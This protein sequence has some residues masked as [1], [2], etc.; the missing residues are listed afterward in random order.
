MAASFSD[1]AMHEP[2]P[3]VRAGIDPY[4]IDLAD[5]TAHQR[6]RARLTVAAHATDPAD[7]LRILRQLGLVTQ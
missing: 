2:K 4:A 3:G 6:Q 1:G 5:N 7:C